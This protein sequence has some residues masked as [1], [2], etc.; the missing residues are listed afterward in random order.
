V[1]D[2][3]YAY[4]G[5]LGATFTGNVPTLR[6]W[7]P[8][9]RSVKL[10]LYNDSNPSTDGSVVAMLADVLAPG[11]WKATGEASWY[12]KYYAYEVEVFVRSTG[13]IEHNL[14]TDPYSVSLSRNSLR[15]HLVDLS[16]A[17]LTPAG[18]DKLCKPPLDAPEDISIYELHVR[19]FSVND[20]SVPVAHRGTF[21]AFTQLSSNGMRHLGALS[22]A[23]LTHVHLLPSFDIATSTRTRRPGSRLA[24]SPACSRTPISS[25]RRLW[26]LP[27]RMDSIGAT[28]R[29]IT[30]CPKGAT[31]PIPMDPPAWLSSARWSRD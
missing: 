5:P 14:V 26:P 13:H 20:T 22:F 2:D 9:A 30:R 8:T 27:K 4:K 3:L 15:S 7:A 10:R 24:I 25:R 16:S 1:L 28:T 17:T 19:D 31:R 21:K 12:G 18:W 23:G 11:V 29:G 6:L